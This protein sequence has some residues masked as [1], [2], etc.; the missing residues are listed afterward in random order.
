M[1]SCALAFL[2]GIHPLTGYVELCRLVGGLAAFGAGRRVP[3]L[4][5]YDHDDLGGCFH[6]VKHHIDA[7][8]DAFVEPAYKERPFIGAGLRMQVALESL[9]L[10]SGWQMFVG[11]LSQLEPKRCVEILTNESRWA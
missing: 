6:A 11:V 10:E 5:A 2:E 3:A 9:W 1:Q 8:L 4:P 7:L